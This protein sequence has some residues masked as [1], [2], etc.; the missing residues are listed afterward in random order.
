[1]RYVHFKITL[2]DK[3]VVDEIFDKHAAA[4]M[5][6]DKVTECLEIISF[7]S[8]SRC[9]FHMLFSMLIG[10]VYLIRNDIL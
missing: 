8:C 7:I 3:K 4:R 5:G 6:I 2:R 1:M 10:N 9:I